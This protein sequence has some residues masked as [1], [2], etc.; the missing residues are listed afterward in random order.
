[1]IDNET[2]CELIK[3][4][5]PNMYRLSCGILRSSADAEDAVSE[6]VLKA[7]ENL[8]SLRKP[9]RFQAWI[10]QIT[11]NEARKI[12]R[13]KMRTTCAEDMEEMAPAFVDNHHE[14]WDAVMRLDVI[15]REVIILYFYENFS[16]KEIARALHIAEGT[17]KS[18]L[19]RGKKKLKEML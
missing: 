16:V 5:S 1:M 9:E 10:M 19:S 6:A 18:R 13:K 15:H 2:F 11:A 4:Y 3:K 14:L 12:Y 7:Y 8:S 17:V